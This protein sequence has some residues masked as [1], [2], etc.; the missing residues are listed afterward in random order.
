MKNYYYYDHV[1]GEGYVI[2][3]FGKLM[4][5]IDKEYDKEKHSVHDTLGSHEICCK[6]NDNPIEY[7]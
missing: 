3:D 6:E 5:F 2:G 4:D 7:D 1:Y